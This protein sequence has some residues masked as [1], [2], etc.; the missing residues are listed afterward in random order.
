LSFY[1]QPDLCAG[2]FRSTSLVK[3]LEHALPVG[4]HIDV[5]TTLPNRYSTFSPEAPVAEQC[6]GVEIR[7]IAL[8]PH[9]SGMADQSKAFVAFSRQVMRHV[10]HR[11]YD[12][13]F[14]TSSRL[15]TAVLGAW[16]ARRKKA[17]LYLDIRDIFVD[18]IKDALPKHLAFLAKRVFSI[19]ESWAVT[20]AARVNLV[21]PGFADYFSSRY[22]DVD[23]LYFTNGID[24]EFISASS[25]IFSGREP[26]GGPLTVLYAGNIGEGQG[27]HA[28]LPILAKR[29]KGRLH[30]KVIGDG[31]RKEALRKALEAAGTGNVELLPPVEREVLIKTYREADVLFLHL[32]D[33]DAFKK[34]LPSKLF[35]YAAVGKPIW[36]GVSGYA[37]EFVR[38][39]I[40]NSAVFHPCD[41]TDAERVFADLDLKT[42]PRVAF[43]KKYA[44]S[45]IAKKMAEEIVITAERGG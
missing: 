10:E 14:A 22:P 44:R 39:E 41:A 19:L 37:A 3:E 34:V 29:M 5:I 35:E 4:S 45:N 8:P 31:G 32:N 1:F 24:E 17:L 40:S 25:D 11:N 30:F 12:L 23:F 33:Y 21:S 18:T 27:L 16:I 26:S 36:A 42:A 43:L 7:R 20:R 15:M 28:I 38:S 2:S 13:V 6:P 9:Q